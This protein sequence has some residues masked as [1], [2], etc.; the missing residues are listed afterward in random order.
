MPDDSPRQSRWRKLAEEIAKFGMVGV[1][2]TAVDF[3][4]F[5]AFI[6][7]GP[8]K[9]NVVSTVAATTV[10]YFLNRHWTYRNRP[11]A[12]LRREYVLFF[13]FNLIGLGIQLAVLGLAK[14]GLHLTEHDHR[15]A[16]NLAKAVGIAIGTV[17]R[18]FAYRTWVFRASP[19]E[20]PAAEPA[21]GTVE[22]AEADVRS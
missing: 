8:L 3:A 10:S 22:S 15:M 2:N 21:A 6:L 5:N 16:L 9:A 1:V 14:Y 11:R 18:F 4:V 20:A 17:F 19:A 13:V 12:A 7:L